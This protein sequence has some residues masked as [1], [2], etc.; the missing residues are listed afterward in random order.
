MKH[1]MVYCDLKYTFVSQKMS[2]GRMIDNFIFCQDE[3]G[4]LT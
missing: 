1:F 3:Q 2:T 4:A